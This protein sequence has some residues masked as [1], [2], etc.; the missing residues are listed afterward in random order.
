MA[1]ARRTAVAVAVLVV[2]SAVGVAMYVT[3][4][5]P[6]R[7]AS[8]DFNLPKGNLTPAHALPS[9]SLR[10]SELAPGS[11]VASSGTG[12]A[13][14]APIPVVAAENFWGSLVSQL[15]GNQT[16]VLSIVTDP[17]ADPHE[18]EANATIALAVAKAQLV[19]VNGAGYDDWALR[20]I[21]SDGNSNQRVLNV[22]D[23]NGVTVGGGI[24]SGNPHMWYY[25]PY[26]NRTLAAMFAD[27]WATRP[28]AAGLFEAN[29]ASLNA[30]LNA[31]FGWAQAIRLHFAGTVVAATESIFAYVAAYTG[32]DLVSPVEFMEAVAEGNDPP[33]RSEVVF[34]CQLESGLVHVLVVNEQTI[35]PLTSSMQ[36]IAAANNVSVVRISETIV[37]PNAT[38]QNWMSAELEALDAALTAASLK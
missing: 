22:A 9:A 2:L 21:A 13:T 18:Y 20:L 14:M 5:E 25:P 34:Q 35:T 19:V 33:L 16:S 12:P 6:S 4:S 23:L 3:S 1:V 28:S 32:L 26:V 10:A 27:L 17:N 15:G 29:Y 36:A 30:S 37:P 31:T 11:P 7:C 24:L 8:L 38:Y